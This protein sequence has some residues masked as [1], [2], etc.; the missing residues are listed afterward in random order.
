VSVVQLV[1][2]LAVES[3]V[4]WAV[5]SVVALAAGMVAQWVVLLVK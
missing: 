3:V 5:E 2:P 4:V 1:V